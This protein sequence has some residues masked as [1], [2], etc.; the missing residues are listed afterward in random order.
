MS[1]IPLVYVVGDVHGCLAELLELEALIRAQSVRQGRPALMVYVGDLI[2]RGPDSAGVL[3]HVYQGVHAGTHALIMGNHELMMLECL[4]EWAPEAFAGLDWPEWLSD[5]RTTWEA[6]EGMA[7]WLTWEDYR[8]FAR[9]LWLGQ[10]GYQTLVSLGCDPHQ[11]DTWGMN[12]ALLQ[13]LLRL[14][15]VWEDERCVVTHAL[16]R[17]RDLELIRELTPLRG[18]NHRA[19]REH[20]RYSHSLIWNRAPETAPVAGTRLHLSGHTPVPHPKRLKKSQAL[21]IDTGCVYGGKLTAYCP[22]TG[23]FI[24][25]AAARNYLRQV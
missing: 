23:R 4:R 16:A 12:P 6:G 1:L 3:W 15:Y 11:P 13:F 21:Q 20:L 25:V 2:D 9:S 17:R 10:G 19:A 7:R 5:Y 18:L 8:I 24:K 14:P 22:E